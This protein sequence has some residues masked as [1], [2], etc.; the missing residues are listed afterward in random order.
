MRHRLF[1]QQFSFLQTVTPIVICAPHSLPL[2]VNP[3]S[4]AACSIPTCSRVAHLVQCCSRHVAYRELHKV[5]IQ[6]HLL[7]ATMHALCMTTICVTTTCVTTICGTVCSYYHRKLNVPK[8]LACGFA[9]LAA[10]RS[11]AGALCPTVFD[12]PCIHVVAPSICLPVFR[13]TS[14]CR[15]CFFGKNLARTQRGQLGELSVRL[16]VG[17]RACGAVPAT[18]RATDSPQANGIK[19][20]PSLPPIVRF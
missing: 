13:T 16:G 11:E 4:L 10:G 15:F 20:R 3:A 19:R 7:V 17:C 12:C 5:S 2:Q 14:C 9:K 6:Q 8:L 18:S 1:A